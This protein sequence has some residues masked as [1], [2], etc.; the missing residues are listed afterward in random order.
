MVSLPALLY[1]HKSKLS[2]TGPCWLTQCHNQQLAGPVLQLSSP[3]GQLSHLS[4]AAP[5]PP[6]PWLNQPMLHPVRGRDSSSS[7]MSLGTAL[8]PVTGGK[9]RGDLSLTQATPGQTRGRASSPALLPLEMAF[10]LS[11]FRVPRYGMA[12]VQ[13]SA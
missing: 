5:A 6:T 9:G 11:T 10:L 4:E 7:L 1:H 3:Q 2:S 13:P 8:P 12:P